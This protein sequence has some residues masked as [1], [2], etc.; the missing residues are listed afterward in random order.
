[1]DSTSENIKQATQVSELR[2]EIVKENYKYVKLTG[3]SNIINSLHSTDFS[4]EP[5]M[6]DRMNRIH[7]LKWKIKDIDPSWH[8]IDQMTLM[9][10]RILDFIDGIDYTKPWEEAENKLKYMAL[11]STIAN[12]RKLH[13]RWGIHLE[14]LETPDKNHLCKCHKCHEVRM[15]KYKII[16]QDNPETE[17]L[18]ESS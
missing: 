17:R 7:V 15:Q 1:M 6:H 16:V 18:D 12:L 10:H 11:F 2:K 3:I 14:S 4:N 13:P 5:L 9:E 8:L